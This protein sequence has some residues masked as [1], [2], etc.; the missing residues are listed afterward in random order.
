RSACWP[1]TWADRYAPLRRT[2]RLR[3]NVLQC[4]PVDWRTRIDP[5]SR[6]DRRPH[7]FQAGAWQPQ[8]AVQ[9]PGPPSNQGRGTVVRSAVRAFGN[10]ARPLVHGPA[11]PPHPPPAAQAVFGIGNLQ[12][13]R[14]AA[15]ILLDGV[16][17]A[18]DYLL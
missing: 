7:S 1:S 2:R 15:W 16:A 9:A 8:Q 6:A 18:R 12:V 17:E 10:G 13:G 11:G 5:L 4:G 14:P 3:G